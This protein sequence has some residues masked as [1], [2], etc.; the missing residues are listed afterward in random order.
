MS[1]GIPYDEALSAYQILEQ[2][3][4]ARE[5]LESEELLRQFHPDHYQGSVIT[6]NVGPNKGDKC[7]SQ[8]AAMLQSDAR[9]DE[10]D[11]A[12]APVKETDILVIGGG[13]TN[14][15]LILKKYAAS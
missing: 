11:L 9:I 2:R 14:A 5:E 4:A 7:H 15:S 1:K 3:E 8:L 6:L 12:G 13:G 10:A